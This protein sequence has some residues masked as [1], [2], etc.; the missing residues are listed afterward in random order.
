MTAVYQ[1]HTGDQHDAAGHIRI[2]KRMVLD[3]LFGSELR[4]IAR[5]SGMPA[6]VLA[7][8]LHGSLHI[9]PMPVP[10]R[11]GTMHGYRIAAG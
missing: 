1:R 2:G 7:P 4:R 10:S 8:F 9:V 6:P 11:G 5:E 3:T